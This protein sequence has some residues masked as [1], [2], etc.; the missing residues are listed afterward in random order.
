MPRKRAGFQYE[1]WCF[2]NSDSLFLE[3]DEKESLIRLIKYLEEVKTSHDSSSSIPVLQK[4]FKNFYQQYDQRN[5]FQIEDYFA[6]DFISWY[7][8]LV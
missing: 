4:D 1:K 7:R 6:A 2:E 8:S 5:R 3:E